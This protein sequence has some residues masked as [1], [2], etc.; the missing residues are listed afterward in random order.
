MLFFSVLHLI[1]LP[2]IGSVLNREYFSNQFQHPL[3][4]YQTI[5]AAPKSHVQ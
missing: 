3:D 5:G 2:P 1:G 4:T